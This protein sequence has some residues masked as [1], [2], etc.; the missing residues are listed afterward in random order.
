MRLMKYAVL[1]G[2][3]LVGCGN[4][5]SGEAKMLVGAYNVMITSD[6]KSDPDVMSISQG[7]HGDILLTFVAGITT[8]VM[9]PN[10]NGIRCGLSGTNVT[11]EMQ[12]CHIDHST[13]NLDG[14]VSGM[15]TIMLDGS[16][17]DFM[18]DFVPTNLGG[19]SMLNYEIT[20]SREM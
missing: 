18:L 1:L 19:T 8:D 17:L 20:G 5:S 11:I 16:N 6:G 9:G 2:L 14:T 7:T 3:Y 13:G 10:P 4:D 15:G 12:P